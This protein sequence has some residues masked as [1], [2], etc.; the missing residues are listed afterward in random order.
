M[1]M[2]PGNKLSQTQNLRSI[3][4][5][6]IDPDARR[7]VLPKLREREARWAIR[8]FATQLLFEVS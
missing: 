5:P 2:L 7:S 4:I 6:L 8:Q 3:T 1:R